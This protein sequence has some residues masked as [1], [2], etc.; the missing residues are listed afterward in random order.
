MTTPTRRAGTLCPRWLILP[1]AFAALAA[2]SASAQ[3]AP[4]QE[5]RSKLEDLKSGRAPVTA[6]SK[7]VFDKFSKYYAARL[8]TSDAQRAGADQG[9]SWLVSDLDKRLLV[10]PHG[11]VYANTFY[12]KLGNGDSQL[13]ERQRKYIDEF[14]KS[15]VEALQGP[16]VNSGNPF[17]RVNAARMIA[18]VCR[19]G[20]DGAAEA[21]LKILAKQDVDD[22]AKFYALQG[23]RNLFAILPD[24]SI[25]EKSIFQKDNT[26]NLSP[27]EVRCIQALT[28]FVFRKP[29]AELDPQDVDGIFYVRREAVRGL[30]L[31]RVQQVKVRGVVQGRPALALLK[32]ARGDGLNPPSNTQQGPDVRSSGERIEA[33]IGFCTLFPPKSDRDMNLDYAVYQVGRALQDLVPLYQPQSDATSTPWKVS[34]Q[35]LR[36]ALATWHA[37]SVDMKLQGTNLIKDLMDTAERDVLGPIEAGNQANMPN[38]ASFGQWV[39][40]VAPKSKSLFKS[41]D[42]TTVNVP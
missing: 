4:K 2:V 26:G 24:P 6:D 39:Q 33:V 3:D 34:A 14:G 9:G 22:A 12:A 1:A 16:A 13:A 17:V 19:S 42:K 28:D 25:P 35:R 10:P 23:I 5:D 8:A 27:L 15:A 11:S 7:A 40:Q 29:P 21:C 41:D 38:A 30:A 31:V 36:D 18:E 20:Y 37:R 32:V